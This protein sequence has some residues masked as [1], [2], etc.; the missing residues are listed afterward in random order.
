MKFCTLLLGILMTFLIY[1]DLCGVHANH[2]SGTNNRTITRTGGRLG[3]ARRTDRLPASRRT[4]GTDTLRRTASGRVIT[5][6]RNAGTVNSRVGTANS[7]V[8]PANTRFGIGN[9]RGGVNTRIDVNARARSTN[10]RLGS[11]TSRGVGIANARVGA[12]NTR[13]G[14]ANTRGVGIANARVGIENT[15]LGSANA[16]AGIANTRG[17]G[18]PSTSATAMEN[19]RVILTP[20]QQGAVRSMRNLLQN[21]RTS[22]GRGGN[23]RL[24]GFL[25]PRADGRTQLQLMPVRPQ[26]QR[27]STLPLNL[28]TI[29]NAARRANLLPRQTARG[30]RNS[31]TAREQ[32]IVVLRPRDGETGGLLQEP[33]NLRSGSVRNQILEERRNAMR[34]DRNLM[35]RFTTTRPIDRTSRTRSRQS[36]VIQAAN[37]IDQAN[38][39]NAVDQGRSI[40]RGTIGM[41]RDRNSMSAGVDQF[42]NPGPD[43]NQF[44]T[45]NPRA[46]NAFVDTATPPI[47]DRTLFRPSS[48]NINE[49]PVTPAP[50]GNTLDPL[51]QRFQSPINGQAADPQTPMPDMD[52]LITTGFEAAPGTQ[53]VPQTDRNVNIQ[54]VDTFATVAQRDNRMLE[55]TPV[56]GTSTDFQTNIQ[57]SAQTDMPPIQPSSTSFQAGFETSGNRQTGT[58]PA[59]TTQ[60]V[61]NTRDTLLTDMTQNNSGQTTIFDSSTNTQVNNIPQTELTSSSMFDVQSTQQAAT[62]QEF[63]PSSQQTQVDTS[64]TSKA[65]T[66]MQSNIASGSVVDTSS[67]AQTSV[68]ATQQ[69]GQM[70]SETTV[71]TGVASSPTL[72]STVIA[73]TQDVQL[74]NTNFP[75]DNSN[76]IDRAMSFPPPILPAS[77]A[78]GNINSQVENIAGQIDQSL[79]NSVQT[80]NMART[81]NNVMSNVQGPSISNTVNNQFDQTQFSSSIGSNQ[82]SN[83]IINSQ[84]EQ[85]R[86]DNNIMSNMATINQLSSNVANNQVGQ[87]R[88]GNDMLSNAATSNQQGSNVANIQVDQGRIANTIMSNQPGSNAMTSQ[89]DQAQF[90]NT[91]ILNNVNSVNVVGSQASVQ[92]QSL[93][94][95]DI[96]PTNTLPSIDN[97]ANLGQFTSNV[98]KNVIDGSSQT[99]QGLQVNSLPN[100]DP[101]VGQFQ[102]QNFVQRQRV[103]QSGNNILQNEITMQTSQPAVGLSNGRDQLTAF[104]TVQTQPNVRNEFVSIEIAGQ[105]KQ[106]GDLARMSGVQNAD[107]V[108]TQNTIQS[109]T[110]NNNVQTGTLASQTFVSNQGSISEIKSNNIINNLPAQ[111]RTVTVET[112]INQPVSVGVTSRERTIGINNNSVLLGQLMP[113]TVQGS[114]PASITNATINLSKTETLLL[115]QALLANST[116]EQYLLKNISSQFL[117]ENV[118]VPTA[119]TNTKTS[120]VNPAYTISADATVNDANTS[121]NMSTNQNVETNILASTFPD[122]ANMIQAEPPGAAETINLSVNNPPPPPILAQNIGNNSQIVMETSNINVQVPVDISKLSFPPQGQMLGMAAEA[123]SVVLSG[124]PSAVQTNAQFTPQAPNVPMDL[125]T[126]KTTS[127][128]QSMNTVSVTKSASFGNSSSMTNISIAVPPTMPSNPEANG[129]SGQ[130]LVTGVPV[131][132]SLP[133][134]VVAAES[135]NAATAQVQQQ[136]NMTE[137][138]NQVIQE[139]ATAFKTASG[140][141]DVAMPTAAVKAL[142]QTSLNTSELVGNLS[143]INN[144]SS[145]SE[146][147]AA[148]G[149]LVEN[150]I[151]SSK[152][153]LGKALGSGAADKPQNVVM[154]ISAL[155]TLISEVLSEFFSHQFNPAKTALTPTAVI[156]TVAQAVVDARKFASPSAS[157]SASG[158]V[159]GQEPV[160]AIFTTSPQMPT[161]P[162]DS[163][164]DFPPPPPF[165]GMTESINIPKTDIVDIRPSTSLENVFSSRPANTDPINPVLIGEPNVKSTNVAGGSASGTGNSQVTNNQPRNTGSPLVS[166]NTATTDPKKD[167]RGVDVQQVRINEMAND[168]NIFSPTVVRTPNIESLRVVTRSNILNRDINQEFRQT[169]IRQP[170]VNTNNAMAV[171]E[172]GTRRSIGI[173]SAQPIP[174]LTNI[175]SDI[176]SVNDR[177]LSMQNGQTNQGG[178]RSGLNVGA[179]QTGLDTRSSQLKLDK[180]QIAP[181][182]GKAEFDAIRGQ[183]VRSR[184]DGVSKVIPDDPNLFGNIPNSLLST[185]K[186]DFT[187]LSPL[188]GVTKSTP[189]ASERLIT[190]INANSGIPDV[191]SLSTGSSF[192]G[193]TNQFSE[194]RMTT[195]FERPS[196]R[197]PLRTTFNSLSAEKS[198][199]FEGHG[200]ST[201]PLV[202]AGGVSVSPSSSYMPSFRS[203]FSGT[204]I[205]RRPLFSTTRA[206]LP[207]TS[208]GSNP[209]MINYGVTRSV[210]TSG[211]SSQ[212]L[213]SNTV[214]QSNPS[215]QNAPTFG[216]EPSKSFGLLGLP[217]PPPSNLMEM[218]ATASISDTA[219]S[220]S[221]LSLMNIGSS[222]TSIGTNP[223]SYSTIIP[224][225]TEDPLLRSTT[226]IRSSPAVTSAVNINTP[227]V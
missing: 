184:I 83:N 4:V 2:L 21:G 90:V 222:S 191:G 17:R 61:F 133:N 93:N 180:Q 118:Q 13:I 199:A 62:T 94:S 165:A 210:Q 26:T 176:S 11:G 114:I 25:I 10:T 156:N 164:L 169:G 157:N 207:S 173:N 187:S 106:Q 89:F 99:Q 75:Q 24:I 172:I 211:S 128:V 158:A 171:S 57:T 66:I 139:A 45:N 74:Q 216:F 167:N 183:I 65:N 56:T 87:G 23:P 197:R 215:T 51:D 81:N 204:S 198:T 68:F 48:V 155:K 126:L 154:D 6:R 137:V 84:L 43:S 175:N 22:T 67:S 9:T 33:G 27:N 19:A 131:S 152:A 174:S 20:V 146:M 78:P 227:L 7:R 111:S 134:I 196:T 151:A 225:V 101:T 208:S 220:S 46:N 110:L 77:S 190:G 223:P 179:L 49:Q 91:A 52:S 3:T 142:I 35:D 107:S 212:P 103:I 147:L 144:N 116:G 145:K 213:L 160:Q 120:A 195:P 226:I 168:Q 70:N 88:F 163:K 113:D 205:T 34:L 161:Y 104:N 182:L 76:V 5:S 202:N 40:S 92:S 82:Q 47:Q 122:T 112:N 127:E 60:P 129:V 123:S 194:S 96:L 159:T 217:P 100:V 1:G 105:T 30:S 42:T 29:I 50:L 166:I 132:S 8:G 117:T 192:Q 64:A 177:T 193:S 186:N 153:T 214:T 140:I 138:K 209:R 206:R 28:R 221:Q 79:F 58:Q 95:P 53:T 98:I 36:A 63:I 201:T 185:F 97:N 44:V 181:T 115:N 85:G 15:R 72:G 41:A 14:S 73:S 143:Q 130:S 170:L 55:P 149:G 119:I 162:K 141:T 109:N 200:S 224:T 69:T 102:N 124:S 71:G 121:V 32:S 59:F 188:L 203:T 178:S 125:P 148:A 16:R 80:D 218:N 39:R 136:L 18:V 54:T 108:N 189:L 37:R 219:I 86:F 31:A 135:G 12:E 38:R 150:A